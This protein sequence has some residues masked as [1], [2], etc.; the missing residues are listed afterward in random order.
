MKDKD[1]KNV[2]RRIEKNII[3]NPFTRPL[4]DRDISIIIPDTNAMID[5]QRMTK[6][7]KG[8]EVKYFNP[9]FFLESL[10]RNNRRILISEEIIREINI[11]EDIK[12]N[13]N[14]YEISKSFLRF[15]RKVYNFSNNLSRNLKYGAD[16]EQ[17]G[18]E[19]YWASKFA[20]IDN[21]KKQE[22]CFSETDKQLLKFACLV[23]T[24]KLDIENRE[25]NVGLV[26][27]LSSDEHLIKGTE[28]MR[29]QAGYSNI[30]CVNLRR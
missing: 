21:P 25:R 28:F 13:D 15:L 30:N 18:L 24:S 16:S 4:F 19:V 17:V 26:H 1:I 23:G 9:E 10:E 7:Y 6:E 3:G 2:L 20:C 22:E 8:Y 14:T 11:H 29:E 12:L 5:L 27:I